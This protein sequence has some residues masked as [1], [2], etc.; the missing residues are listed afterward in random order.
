MLIRRK[1]LLVG[2]M[3]CVASQQRIAMSMFSL[4][5][6]ESQHNTG[7]PDDED[8]IIGC[9]SANASLM[10]QM[11]ILTSALEPFLRSKIRY[12]VEEDTDV[13][14]CHCCARCFAHD[15]YSLL[16]ACARN[17]CRRIQY[18]RNIY[19]HN[20]YH[21]RYHVKRASLQAREHY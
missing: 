12:K 11:A 9:L 2:M 3:A 1:V 4:T 6:D 15:L 18:S 13:S 7:Q 19:T 21:E 20:H 8:F 14:S 16:V 17:V 10:A 5:D